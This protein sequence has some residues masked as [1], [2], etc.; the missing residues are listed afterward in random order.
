MLEAFLYHWLWQDLYVPVWP[1][2]VASALLA[3]LVLVRVHFLAAMHKAHHK[4]KLDQA[5]G[6][7]AEVLAAINSAQ[8]S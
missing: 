5:A 2:I 4:E 6:H 7:H 1:N 3:V 8:C